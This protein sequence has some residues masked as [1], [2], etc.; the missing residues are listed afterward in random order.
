MNLLNQ[1]VIDNDDC[2]KKNRKRLKII[3][4]LNH[5]KVV[6]LIEQM[7]EALRQLAL[8]VMTH[9]IFA[10]SAYSPYYTNSNQQS[11]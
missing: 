5:F 1:V 9:N 3:N 11:T 10:N 6:S 4:Y 7:K 8:H 2:K